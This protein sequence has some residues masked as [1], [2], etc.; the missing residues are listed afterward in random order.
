MFVT[1]AAVAGTTAAKEQ[2]A[3]Q[4]SAVRTPDTASG[5]ECLRP[6]AALPL[7]VFA[8]V[9]RRVVHAVQR[10]TNMVLQS[11]NTTGAH[12][13]RCPLEDEAKVMPPSFSYIVRSM[14]AVT[15]VAGEENAEG[16][17][18]WI[19]SHSEEE[20][21]FILSIR[22]SNINRF[23]FSDPTKVRLFPR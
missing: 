22:S 13:L 10:H 12:Y 20:I 18:L 14:P 17:F 16:V 7:P 11:T 15:G 2:A 6:P 23:L 5:H 9:Q 4:V 21:F 1:A 8:N 3:P 19:R